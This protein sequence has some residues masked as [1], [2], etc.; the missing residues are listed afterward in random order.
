MH[1]HGGGMDDRLDMDDMMNGGP[2]GLMLR[3]FM[4][5]TIRMH[6]NRGDYIPFV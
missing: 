4:E 3:Q 6:G 2:L 5:S 1:S